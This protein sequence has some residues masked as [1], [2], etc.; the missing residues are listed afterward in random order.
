MK[1]KLKW[2]LIGA[3]LGGGAVLY[4]PD[5]QK[6][7]VET[8]GTEAEVL[9][10]VDG[11]T[12]EIRFQGRVEKVRLIGIDT[13]ESFENAKAE[14][15]A[16]RSGQDVKKIVRQGNEAK[17]YVRALVPAGTK[18]RVEPDVQERD[19]Y[20]RLLAYLYFEDGRMINEEIVK[21]GYANLMTY[22]PNVRYEERFLLA[23]RNARA[24]RKGLWKE[25]K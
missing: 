22:P 9:K 7:L 20:G 2:L 1:R 21:A 14:K 13:P 10:V 23:Y 18:V 6:R 24:N 8:N 17:N 4:F 16:G 3:V 19:K 12:F 25:E 15:D 5:L 11:D